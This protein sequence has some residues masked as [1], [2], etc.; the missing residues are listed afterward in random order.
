[1]IVNPFTYGNPIS[2]PKRFFG[3][4]REVEQV[5]SRLRNV[6]F[7]SS[8]IVGER[9]VG[10]TSLFNYL[11]HPVV[12]HAYGLDS[13]KYLFVYV[14]LQMLDSSTTPVRLWQRLLRQMA[15]SCQDAEVKQILESMLQVACYFLFEA[16]S[17]SLSIDE[18]ML[19]LCNEFRE[20]ATPHW[21]NYWHNSYDQEKILL[22][23]LALLKQQQ[24]RIGG[25]TFNLGQLQDLYTHSEQTLTH[26][27]KRGLVISE[28]DS[29]ALFNASFGEWICRE[30]TDT[31]H[32]EQSYEDWLNSNKSMME[33]FSAKARNELGDILPRISDKY[34][35]LIIS[36]V[37]DPKNLI[38]VAGLLKTAL[39]FG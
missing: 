20:E 2:D 38:M 28:G 39:G 3:R 21:D 34:R 30:I 12:R 29:Y 1:M 37:S 19:F 11:M 14:D 16:Y 33:R 6:E 8:S 15:R 5:F 22:T 24:R 32:D 7:E 26:L 18:R 17:K 13:S 35:E 36:W 31:M 25:R 4:K 27:E 9:R 23:A 10:K